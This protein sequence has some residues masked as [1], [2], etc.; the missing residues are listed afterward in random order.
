VTVGFGLVQA[1]AGGRLAGVVAVEFEP[2]LQFDDLNLLRRQLGR[3]VGPECLNHRPQ[4]M[5]QLILL[6]V[7]E[8]TEVGEVLHRVGDCRLALWGAE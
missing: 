8:L 3:H 2:G 7:T 6:S 4:R 5:D 1:I